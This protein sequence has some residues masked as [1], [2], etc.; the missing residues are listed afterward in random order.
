MMQIN[1]Q[2][3][4]LCTI[5]T[6]GIA[7]FCYLNVFKPTH[8]IDCKTEGMINIKV[9]KCVKCKKIKPS[10]NYSCQKYPLY[11]VS[12][13]PVGMINVRIN[14][15][16]KCK[17]YRA[18]FSTSPNEIAILCIKCKT[19]GM[20]NVNQRKCII[21][22]TKNASYKINNDSCESYCDQCKLPYM[23]KIDIPKIEK[24]VY[25]RPKKILY[26]LCIVCRLKRASFASSKYDNPIYC[27]KCKL[28]N[29]IE[30]RN[31][32]C[33]GCEISRPSFNYP[34][35]PLPIFCKSCKVTGMVNVVRKQKKPTADKTFNEFEFI[36]TTMSS[37]AEFESVFI[38]TPLLIMKDMIDY[39]DRLNKCQMLNEH[40]INYQTPFIDM[41][42][43]DNIPQHDNVTQFDN[44]L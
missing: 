28:D 37:M 4:N 38:D 15:C 24:S 33:A 29:M 44:L 9:N 13:M 22:K 8:C 27:G 16:K 17:I 34:T 19:D 1:L 35:Q 7:I 5:C 18:T 40:L 39:N 6:K 14:K 41:K 25:N 23:I 26:K 10:Y 11:C 12:C 20:I 2:N 36:E 43:S 30:V 32:K 42:L 3:N 21:C 31:I